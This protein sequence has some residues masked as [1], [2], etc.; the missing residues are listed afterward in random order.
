MGKDVSSEILRWRGERILVLPATSR[1]THT[2]IWA[3]AGNRAKSHSGKQLTG[4]RAGAEENEYA[5][6]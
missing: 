2:E 3:S 4:L 6:S 1:E 5:P